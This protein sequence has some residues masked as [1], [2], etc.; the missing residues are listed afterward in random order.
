MIIW[1]GFIVG[2]LLG[3]VLT[4]GYFC[5]YSGLS[6]TLMFRNFKIAKASIWAVLIAMIGFHLMVG[7]GIITLNPKPFFWA[8]SIIGGMIFGLGM[9]MVGGCAGGT[10]FKIGSGL[11]GYLIAGLGI[12]LGGF[13]TA[14]GFLKPIRLFLQESTKVTIAG[15]N[16]TLTSL[17]EV[18]PWILVLLFSAIFIWLLFKLRT[19]EKESQP[20]F[21]VR[22]LKLRWP[23]ALTGIA[24]GIIGMIAFVTSAAA[25][26]N[27]PLGIVE[28][29]IAILKSFLT[30]QFIFNWVFMLIPGIIL[31]AMIASLLASEFRFRL[32]NFKTAVIMLV[33][34]FLMGGGAVLGAGCNVTHILSGIP[35]L[36]IGSIVSGIIIFGTAYLVDYFRFIRKK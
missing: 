16:P 4:R 27:Y 20:S 1:S 9:T 30:G 36:A 6:D 25:G 31:G 29:Y 18:N 19:E 22:L 7:L 17:L 33:G 34:G 35:Q 26:R 3:F 12:A 10:T 13:F 23:S 2:L 5:Q 8:A 28:G 14:E 15:K 24:I 21:F 11:I 32:P